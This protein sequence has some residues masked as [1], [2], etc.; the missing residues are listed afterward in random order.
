MLKTHSFKSYFSLSH[1]PYQ[2]W[3]EVSDTIKEFYPIGVD[4]ESPDYEMYTGLQKMGQIMEDNILDNKM[5][6]KRWGGFLKIIRKDLNKSAE[7]V[8]STT[9]GLRP[10]YSADLIL[11]RYE[12]DSLLRIKKLTFAVSLI[13][14]FYSVCGIDETFIRNKYHDYNGGGYHAINV[15]TASPYEEFENE[16]NHLQ[17][18]IETHFKGYKF[19]PISMC[20]KMV[21]GLHHDFLEA[22]TVYDALFNHLF[23][24]YYSPFAR[25]RGDEYYGYGENISGI[26]VTLTA[27]PPANQIP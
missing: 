5:Y 16:F 24:F 17:R 26:K 4:R 8:H 27:P 9:Y 14:P 7:E 1:G 18:R 21:E 12:D 6:R 23:N 10:G 20:L 25:Y 2:I 13:G 15:I 11:E 22:G 3:K 19:V